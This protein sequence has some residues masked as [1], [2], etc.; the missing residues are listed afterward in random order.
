MKDGRKESA[1]HKSLRPR[2][3]CQWHAFGAD[4]SGAKTSG[5]RNSERSP[6]PK[7]VKE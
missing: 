3:A 6:S 1:K 2:E 4:R 5:L 7:S